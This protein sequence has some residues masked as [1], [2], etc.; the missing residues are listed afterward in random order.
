MRACRFR[1]EASGGMEMRINPGIVSIQPD[2][3]ISVLAPAR[4]R[5]CD[6]LLRRV[7]GQE[8]GR[9][10]ELKIWLTGHDFPRQAK[11]LVRVGR[12][13]NERL[14][15]SWPLKPPM[16]KQLGIEWCDH[17]RIEVQAAE[18]VHLLAAYLKKMRRVRQRSPIGL[19]R[20]VKF[21]LA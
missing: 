17:N 14:E 15:K 16:A 4:G 3:K 18:I 7:I 8:C 13:A 19:I 5:G 2:S 1:H 12:L 6:R 10:G 11:I 20:I 9:S 21:L